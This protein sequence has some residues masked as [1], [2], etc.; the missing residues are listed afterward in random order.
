MRSRQ[1]AWS[2]SDSAG[3]AA[4]AAVR[5]AVMAG[6]HAAL[7]DYATLDAGAALSVPTPEH[8]LPLLYA[9]ESDRVVD[10]LENIA[11]RQELRRLLRDHEPV[12]RMVY[13]NRGRKARAL[14]DQ[15]DL[16][17]RE[18]MIRGALKKAEL[19]MR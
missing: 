15:D 10:V 9:R 12:R 4:Q 1:P 5:A 8:Y 11:G 16:P 2:V 6:R 13:Q 19:W 3:Q 17:K 18:Q 7:A 14:F